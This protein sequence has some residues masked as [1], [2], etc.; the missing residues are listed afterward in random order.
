MVFEHIFQG[1]YVLLEAKDAEAENADDTPVCV[2]KDN[3]WNY[4]YSYLLKP[5][6]IHDSTIRTKIIEA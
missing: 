5:V 6:Y 1:T 2:K 4:P 3:G